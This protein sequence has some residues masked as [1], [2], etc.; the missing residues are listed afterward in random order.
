MD[1]PLVRRRPRFLLTILA[2]LVLAPFANAFATVIPTTDPGGFEIDGD[3]IA[4]SPTIDVTDWVPHDPGN[5]IGLLTSSGTP[6][7]P[8]R[9]W[10]LI[11]AY[12][13]SD[14]VFLAGT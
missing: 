6:Q 10:H 5:G 12:D 14:D 11:D 4:N 3:L 7:D 8:N 2:S 1:R 9:T 13:S